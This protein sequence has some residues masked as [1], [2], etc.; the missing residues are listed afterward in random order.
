MYTYLIYLHEWMNFLWNTTNTSSN[1]PSRFWIFFYTQYRP[2]TNKDVIVSRR[3]AFIITVAWPDKSRYFLENIP[4]CSVVPTYSILGRYVTVILKLYNARNY[5]RKY[6]FFIVLPSTPVVYRQND[7]LQTLLLSFFYH[8]CIIISAQ[9]ANVV[10]SSKM[11][12]FF[13]T[14]LSSSIY[15]MFYIPLIPN[16]NIFLARYSYH[17]FSI[18]SSEWNMRT[19]PT[20]MILYYYRDDRQIALNVS[21]LNYNILYYIHLYRLAIRFLV[22]QSRYIV[23]FNYSYI[24]FQ[25]PRFQILHIIQ[26]YFFT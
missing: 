18:S 24:T 12:F 14:V 2:C 5:K 6:R 3:Y 16:L 4:T 22:V 13:K 17:C 19:T 23:S 10:Q 26:I 9:H 8:S 20:V 15:N 25:T 21:I 7:R 11:H 1:R